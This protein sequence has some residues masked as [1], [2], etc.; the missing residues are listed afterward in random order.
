MISLG[1]LI[2]RPVLTIEIMRQRATLYSKE[3]AMR[4]P[5]HSVVKLINHTTESD[6][7]ISRM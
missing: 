4:F 5:V 3:L 6:A 1:L 7:K 2:N